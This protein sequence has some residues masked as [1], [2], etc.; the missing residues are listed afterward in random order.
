[1]EIMKS[2]DIFPWNDNFNT[3]IS[4]I[5][6]QHRKLVQLLNMLASH[7]AFHSDIP[8]L[9]I[10]FEELADYAVYHFQTEEEI[11]HEYLPDDPSESSHKAV[12]DS[13]VTQ[14][15]KL[16]NA[17]SSKSTDKV[18][19]EVLAF[20]TRWLASHILENDRHMAM[21][22][23]AMQSGLPLESAKRHAKEKMSGS[24]RALIDIILSIYESLSTNT[25][26]L[27]RELA[28]HKR[29]D[30]LL[31]RNQILILSMLENSPIAARIATL[32]GRKVIYANKR[33][34]HLINSAPERVLGVDPRQYYANAQSYEDTLEQLGRGKTVRDKLVELSIPGSG[35]VWTLSTYLNIEYENEPAIL[36]WFYDVTEIREIGAQLQLL[37]ANISDL[38]CRHDLE[39]NY[40]FVTPACQTLQ[41]FREDELLGHSC[42]EFFHADDVP[43]IQL[44]HRKILENPNETFTACYRLRHKNGS[45]VWVESRVRATLNDENKVVDIV[46]AKRDISERIK[47]EQAG[48][49]VLPRGD[50]HQFGRAAADVEDQGA[51]ER[52]IE[53]RVAAHQRQAR[54]FLRRDQ[55]QIESGLVGDAF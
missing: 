36:G 2:I 30:T 16:K 11:W 45:Y 7:V 35:T 8:A 29:Q 28:E 41:G 5:D 38:I 6:E 37:T 54:F 53:Q 25:L 27:M 40:L 9:N 33:Y 43:G 4:K 12:H 17:E 23:Q 47:T 18:I 15:L 13:F 55:D 20:L 34:A 48:R 49:G 22:V 3:G 31:Q 46:S 21:V 14:V 42:Y 19:E 32:G 51:R 50:P 10:I 52:G 44:I 26:Q 39:G 1:M 24:T